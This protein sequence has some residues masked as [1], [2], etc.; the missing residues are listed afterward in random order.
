VRRAAALAGAA[1]A[2]CKRDFLIFASYRTRLFTTFFTSTVSLTLFYYVSRLV[3]SPRIGSPDDYYAFVVVGLMIFA[4]L[5]STLSTPVTTLRA[6]LQAGTFERMVLSPFGPVRSIASLLIFPLLL[7]VVVALVS[8]AY[9]AIVFGLELRWST[10]AGALPVAILGA[11]AFAPFGLLMTGAVVVFKQTNA[12]AT[13][14]IT[15]ITLLAGVYFPVSLLPD[16]IRWASEVQPFTPAVDLLRNALVG[17]P[18]RAPLWSEVAKLAA[19]AAVMLP[20]SFL[21]LSKAVDRSRRQGTII[22]Y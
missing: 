16:W 7:S 1:G 2:I 5:T 11:A 22:E 15:G 17:T 20:L 4:V 8:L 3:S 9:A 10:A 21:V 18:L 12:G 14:V 6:E 13:F 19:F